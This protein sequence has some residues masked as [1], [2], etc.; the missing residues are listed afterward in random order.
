VGL[1]NLR[2]RLARLYHDRAELELVRNHEGTTLARMQ[3]P[4]TNS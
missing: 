4:M 3:L 1:A 2:A